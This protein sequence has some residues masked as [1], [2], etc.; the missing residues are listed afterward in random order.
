MKRFMTGALAVSLLLAC[1]SA[2][3]YEPKVWD[4][5]S[6]WGQSGATPAPVKDTVR[7]GYWWWPTEPASNTNDSEAWG[8]RGVVYHVGYAVAPPV[9]PPV[10]PPPPPPT[11]PPKQEWVKPVLNHVLF[12]FDK[13]VLKAEGQAETDKV[14]SHMKEWPATTVSITGHTCNIGTDAYN[15]GLGQRRADAVKAYMV[16]SGIDTARISTVSKG[17][18]EPAVPNTSAENRKLNRRAVFDV[19]L[20]Q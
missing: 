19:L 15:M 5:L 10:T 17:E 8:N 4:D 3:A 14:V 16:Q 1:G 2:L 18:S 7:S 13:S 9:E 6:W 12:D 11:A 20:S